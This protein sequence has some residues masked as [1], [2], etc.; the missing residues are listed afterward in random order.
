M[1]LVDY[2]SGS[3]YPQT[4]AQ[5]VRSR[6]FSHITCLEDQGRVD[7]ET[8]VGEMLSKSTSTQG[9]LSV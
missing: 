5:K 6:L 9:I 7:K 8:E 2:L 4:L 3:P 1:G